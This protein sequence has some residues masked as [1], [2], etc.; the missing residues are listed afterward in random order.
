MSPDGAARRARRPQAVTAW[1][2]FGVL[3]WAV[4]ALVGAGA[5]A[6]GQTEQRGAERADPAVAGE[7]LWNRDCASCHGPEGTGTRWGPD[8][9]DKGPAGVHLTV[10]TGRM[11]LEDLTGLADAPPGEDDRQVPR[12]H[13]G[14]RYLPGQVSALVAHARTILDGPDVP[15]VSIAE[16]DLSRGGDLFQRNCAS[17]HAWSGRGGALTNGHTATSLDDS[18]PT[19]VIE[20]MRT[21]LGTMPRFSTETLDEAEATDVAAYVAYL[22]APRSPGGDPLGYLGPAAEGAVAGAALVALLLVVRWIGS[23]RS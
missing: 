22:H 8:L 12:G 11:P 3:V 23:R 15:A 5:P 21:G 7:Q 14:D 20:A 13:R 4:S 16:A 2:L 19:Q 10:T 18:T 17:C 9:R 1:A 6:S